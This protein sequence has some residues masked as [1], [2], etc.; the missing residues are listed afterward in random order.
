MSLLRPVW[1]GGVKTG[2]N[3]ASTKFGECWPSNNGFLPGGKP[4]SVRNCRTG[5]VHERTPSLA[6]QK[7]IPL[8][9]GPNA[10]SFYHRIEL[11]E[12]AGQRQT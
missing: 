11:I 9:R 10:L 6:S 5:T 2:E 3:R 4:S 8:T 1:L 12:L 7:R